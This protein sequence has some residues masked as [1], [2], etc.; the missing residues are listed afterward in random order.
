MKASASPIGICAA[1][2]SL[3]GDPIDFVPWAQGEDVA[4]RLID[5]LLGHGFRYFHA[6]PVCSDA[7]FIASAIDRLDAPPGWTRG[8][9]Y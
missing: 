1:A 6:A 3:P 7:D 4:P 9:R 8:V 2:Y 5:S